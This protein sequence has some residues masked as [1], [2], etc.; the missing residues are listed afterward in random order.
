MSAAD[1]SA[2]RS[3][4]GARNAAAFPASQTFCKDHAA[5][6]RALPGST[7]PAAPLCRARAA[8]WRRRPPP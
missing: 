7:A 8:R 4:R 6:M 2:P 5:A 3:P 1:E